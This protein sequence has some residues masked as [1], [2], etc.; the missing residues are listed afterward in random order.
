MAS[1]RELIAAFQAGRQE[2]FEQIVLRHQVGLINF[3][4]RFL[5]DRERAED[6][7]QEVFLRLYLHADRYV[8]TAKLTTY[9]YHIAKNLCLDDLRRRKRQGPMQSIDHETQEGYSLRDELIAEEE[10]PSD[11]LEG[12]DRERIVQEALAKLPEEQRLVVVLSEIRG[13]KYKEIA[14]ILEIPVG[15]VKSRMH[16][17]MHKLREIL[18]QKGITDAA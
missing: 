2:A 14:E 9:L 7:T 6:Y 17:A 15:T 4:Y 1:D 11:Q 10:T 13:M 16:T 3:F 18:E 12:K 8:P 5:G